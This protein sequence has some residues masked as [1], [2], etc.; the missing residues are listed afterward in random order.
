MEHRKITKKEARSLDPEPFC[1]ILAAIERAARNGTRAHLEQ[2]HVQALIQ[3][4]VFILLSELK[5]E[6]MSRK[7]AEEPKLTLAGISSVNT[8]FGTA[9]IATTGVSVGSTAGPL[10]AAVSASAVAARM[11]RQKQR[12]RP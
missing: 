9:S 11:I 5:Q 1:E 12:S 10:A 7:W 6:E 4:P 3:S 2:H 8:G